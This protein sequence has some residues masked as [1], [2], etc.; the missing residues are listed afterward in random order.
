MNKKTILKK[1][2]TR[3]PTQRQLCNKLAE[4][5][6]QG[7]SENTLR[8]LVEREVML[9]ITGVV[10]RVGGANNYELSQELQAAGKRLLKS[11]EF[12]P[13]IEGA[14]REILKAQIAR[15]IPKETND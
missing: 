5:A 15:L 8:Q 3:K 11:R 9:N 1:K 14:A 4:E 6:T 2:T 12:K 7:M 13:V 10:R